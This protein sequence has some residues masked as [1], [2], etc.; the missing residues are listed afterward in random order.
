M[1]LGGRKQWG[2]GA[3]RVRILNLC[4]DTLTTGHTGLRAHPTCSLQNAVLSADAKIA[5]AKVICALIQPWGTSHHLQL[6]MSKRNPTTSHWLGWLWGMGLLPG[7]PQGA[8]TALWEG[9]GATLYPRGPDEAAGLGTLSTVAHGPRRTNQCASTSAHT[10]KQGTSW[11]YK[12]RSF[13]S[14][15]SSPS[16]QEWIHV[17]RKRLRIPPPRNSTE[18]REISQALRSTWDHLCPCIFMVELLLHPA[19]L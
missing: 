11:E 13:P 15:I 18:G 12:P 6:N 14:L 3:W 8:H 16:S 7:V 10:V 2:N 5:K 4:R 17:R 1:L 19:W 9:P